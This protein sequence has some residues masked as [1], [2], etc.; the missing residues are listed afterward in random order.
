MHKKVKI[1]YQKIKKK[2]VIDKWPRLESL[3]QNPINLRKAW[4]TFKIFK[5]Y[6]DRHLPVITCVPCGEFLLPLYL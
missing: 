4:Y 6:P 3:E 5:P 2:N 1:K